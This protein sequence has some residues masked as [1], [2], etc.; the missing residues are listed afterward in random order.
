MSPIRRFSRDR[1]GSGAAIG[2][3][4]T[5]LSDEFNER[6]LVSRQK[7]ASEASPQTDE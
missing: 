5:R 2:W 4:P 6:F 3:R 1:R 7:L